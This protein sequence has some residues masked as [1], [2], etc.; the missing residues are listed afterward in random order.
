[1]P[2]G[3]NLDVLSP[4]ELKRGGSDTHLPKLKTT[5][6]FKQAGILA[7]PVSWD[8]RPWAG[9]T[10]P[11]D[12]GSLCAP[13]GSRGEARGH[14]SAISM[15]DTKT[16]SLPRCARSIPILRPEHKCDRGALNSP[17]SPSPPEQEWKSVP[18]R[19]GQGT[20]AGGGRSPVVHLVD[21][22]LAPVSLQGTSR[23]QNGGWCTV[24]AQ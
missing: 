20:K 23:A 22:G 2:T 17:L 7:T 11:T 12:Q 14:T 19:R 1:M 13:D 6:T 3:R 21:P 16:R 10:V 9:S 8:S 5:V 18:T 24:R 4:T 15:L